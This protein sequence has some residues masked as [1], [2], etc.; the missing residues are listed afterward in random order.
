MTRCTETDVTLPMRAGRW[1]RLQVG[2]R[3]GRY[4]LTAVLGAGAMGVVYRAYDAVLGRDVALKSLHVQDAHARQRFV[5]EARSMARVS[6]PN[7]VQVFDVVRTERPDG[8]GPQWLIAMELVEGQTL[9][10]WLQTPRS[11]AEIVEAFAAA[12]RGLAA[13]HAAGLVH[14]DFKPANVIVGRDGRVRVTDFGLCVSHEE[15][16]DTI[17]EGGSSATMSID[18][19]RERTF[20]GVVVGTPAYM[21][22]EQHRGAVLCP[23]ADQFAFCSALFEALFDG[24]P[25]DGR[26]C[27]EL[28]QQKHEGEIRRTR[29]GRRVP[30]WLR[31]AVVRGLRVDPERR[32][33][34]MPA[35]L[36]ALEGPRA[37]GGSWRS[38]RA[39]VLLSLLGGGLGLAVTGGPGELVARASQ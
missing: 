34:S 22:P 6:H 33:A 37:R 29:G 18:E 38:L 24:R 4:R 12:G 36:A 1:P 28:S 31:R 21:A 35:L 15:R 39:A 20:P 25:F 17:E 11:T 10:R 26:S 7:V 27:R 14:R 3:V 9:D 30:G 32:F 13:A 2:E 23:A 16:A 8:E 5:Q 19:L